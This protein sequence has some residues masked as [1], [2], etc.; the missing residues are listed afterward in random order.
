MRTRATYND[1]RN[2]DID[3]YDDSNRYQATLS[4]QNEGRKSATIL[5]HNGTLRHSATPSG[6]RTSVPNYGNELDK[7]LAS[8]EGLVSHRPSYKYI[9]DE[10][11]FGEYVGRRS[12]SARKSLREENNEHDDY[13]ELRKSIKWRDQGDEIEG[14]RSTL[15]IRQDEQRQNDDDEFRKYLGDLKQRRLLK[16]ERWRDHLWVI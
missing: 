7:R 2:P 10:D 1:D 5:R 16:I 15:P 6:L 13:N 14:R 8:N 12:V 11:T 3:G 4:R 9:R